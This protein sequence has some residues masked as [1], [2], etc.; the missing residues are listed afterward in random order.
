MSYIYTRKHHEEDSSVRGS[1]PR[2]S[3]IRERNLEG[4]LPFSLNVKGGEITH[5]H[6][7]KAQIHDSKGSDGNRRIMSVMTS[8]FHQS[9]SINAKGGNC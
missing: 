5:M 3:S 8:I 4:K 7:E 1:I 6:A 9:V 2:E